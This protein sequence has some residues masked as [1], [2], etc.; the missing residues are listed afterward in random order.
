MC[1]FGGSS[2]HTFDT[3]VKILRSYFQQQD[4]FERKLQ[5]PIAKATGTNET[6]RRKSIIGPQHYEMNN[7]VKSSDLPT[8]PPSPLFIDP[9]TNLNCLHVGS[10][11]V[12][13]RLN[14]Y[15]SE[16]LTQISVIQ[17]MKRHHHL[18]SLSGDNDVAHS[19]PEKR[20]PMNDW[21]LTD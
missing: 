16:I 5:G 10:F 4:L 19:S 14:S 17:G 15:Y 20:H 8:M 13:S 18:S 2:K 12:P 9:Y 3:H 1:V 21:N 11:G 6:R 7:V